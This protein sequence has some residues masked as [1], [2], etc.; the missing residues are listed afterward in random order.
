MCLPWADDQV[1]GQAKYPMTM[2]LHYLTLGCDDLQE[3][4]VLL[5]GIDD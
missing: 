3:G 1:A 2:L 4:V 5:V